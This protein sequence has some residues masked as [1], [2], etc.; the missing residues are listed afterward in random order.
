MR[1]VARN[2]FV[3]M[4]VVETL[5]NDEHVV[6]AEAKEEEGQAGVHRTVEQSKGGGQP[7]AD[8]DAQSDVEDSNHGKCSLRAELQNYYYEWSNQISD[9]QPIVG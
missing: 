6:D 2:L 8:Q 4:E 9:T 1:N 3:R 5:D 7:V